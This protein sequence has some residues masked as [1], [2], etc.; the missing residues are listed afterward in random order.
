MNVLKNTKSSLLTLQITAECECP[1]KDKIFTV[2]PPNHRPN[3][4]VLKNTK[5]SLL[6]F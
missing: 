1:E 3:V 5:S 2:N 4:N 6:T